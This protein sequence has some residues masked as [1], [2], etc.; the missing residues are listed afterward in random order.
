MN[1]TSFF[2]IRFLALSGIIALTNALI[3]PVFRDDSDDDKDVQFDDMILTKDQ[4]DAI[5]AET[6][7]TDRESSMNTT[8]ANDMILTQDQI[9]I[10][11]GG[12]EAED[13]GI[14]PSWAK[15]WNFKDE[16]KPGKIIVPYRLDYKF[17]AIQKN[18]IKR[19]L[20]EIEAVSCIRYL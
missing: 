13:R 16:N 11:K 9:D 20:K 3:N 19:A 2:L 7:S 15:H 8:Y 12:M 5:N 18:W 4:I 10:I 14:A 1:W 6:E 17:S